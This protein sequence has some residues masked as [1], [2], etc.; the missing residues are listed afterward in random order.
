MPRVLSA[1]MFFPRGGSATVMRA[2]AR[3]L[4]SYGWEPTILSGS[5]MG[6]AGYGD[7]ARFYAGLG[8]RAA[9]FEP[10]G[11]MPMHPSYEDRPGAADRI[12]A[13]IDDDE[14]ERHVAA[15]A[16]QLER[17]GAREADVLHLHH[18]TPLH[19]AAARVAPHVPVVTH[20]HGTELLMLEAIA[21]GAPWPHAEAWARR[22]RRWAHASARV[23]VLSPGQVQRAVEL[24]GI[25]P[26]LCVV[27][28]NGF[29]PELFDR[30]D[31]D[32]AA[33]WRHHLVAAP[34]GWAPGGEEGSIAYTDADV[35]PLVAGG[36]VA[37]CV[38]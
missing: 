1:L 38:S 37:I 4:P 3:E 15:W 5:R 36:P 35:A 22:M 9:R 26:E 30:L 12:F 8:V 23:L 17:A 14:F 6:G 25:A 31:V 20:L 19:E 29:D 33:H 32:R 13:V 24:L 18:L 34:R 27:S 10:E 11:D 7:A 16:A 21:D 2:L 28:P